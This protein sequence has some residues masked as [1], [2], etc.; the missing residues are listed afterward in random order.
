V[1]TH[2]QRLET[3]V[4]KRLGQRLQAQ[5]GV[6]DV[7][8]ETYLRALRSIARFEWRT[9]ASFFNWLSAIAHNVILEAASRAKTERYIALDVE[10]DLKGADPS[11]GKRLRRKERLMRLE[12]A[13]ARLPPDYRKI[14]ELVRLQ[15]LSVT[16]AAQRIGR[17][18]NTT[19]QLLLRAL[20]RLREVFGETESFALPDQLKELPEDPDGERGRK[21]TR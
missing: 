20:R 12:E 6:D 18:P 17:S 19:S 21:S 13:L 10:L 15:G 7:L 4:A 3:V 5:Q 8:Q 2:R 11:P 1:E 16:D 14:L 9:E